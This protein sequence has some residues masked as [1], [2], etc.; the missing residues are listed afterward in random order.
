MKTGSILAGAVLGLAL[1]SQVG[2]EDRLR[3]GLV[4]GVNRA[5]LV[6]EGDDVTVDAITRA[7]VGGVVEIGLGERLAVRMEPTYVQKGGDITQ[8]DGGPAGRLET[9]MLELPVLLK[10]SLGERVRPYL[11][12]GPA[13][14]IRLGEDVDFHL[15]GG[16]YTGDFSEV[17]RALD[18]GVV[19]GVGLDVPLRS[20]GAF[21]EC[22]YTWGLANRMKGGTVRVA[23]PGGADEIDFD[24]EEDRFEMR[25]LQVLAGV[26]FRLR[27]R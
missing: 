19:F 10:V 14:G 11:L 24:R 22:R 15:G 20:A 21:V 25:G 2:A 7:A 16:T 5:D 13:I 3:L 26:T 27:R 1:A 23:G 8:A 9:G 4:G 6:V 17:T 18:P 12:A